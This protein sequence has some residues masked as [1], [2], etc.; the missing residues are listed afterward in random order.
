MSLLI[1]WLGKAPEVALESGESSFQNLATQWVHAVVRQAQREDHEATTKGE[2]DHFDQ[3]SN[4][5]QL[6]RK[7]FDYVEANASEYWNVPT[8]D[9]LDGGRS[10]SADE[11]SPGESADGNEEED[12]DESGGLFRAAYEDV[13]YRDSTDDGFEGAIFDTDSATDTELEQRSDQIIDRLTF[14]TGL[15]K[16]WTLTAAS[17]GSAKSAGR[18]AL[19]LP[20]DYRETLRSWYRSASQI[21]RGLMRLIETISQE[22]IGQPEGDHESMVEYDRRRLMKETMIEHAIAT[23]VEASEAER[24]LLAALWVF[25]ESFEGG[26]NNEVAIERELVETSELLAA[27]MRRDSDDTAKRFKKMLVDLPKLQI[28]Y[29]PLSKS[30]AGIDIARAR[31]R[32][33]IIENL[34]V[35]LPR[36]G[37]LADTVQLLDAARQMERNLPAGRGAVTQFDELFKVGFREMVDALVRATSAQ[38]GYLEQDERDADSVL[39]QCLERLTEPALETWL[40]HSRTLR[41]SILEGVR[42]PTAWKRLVEFI[43]NYGSDLFTQRFLALGN[44]RAILHCGTDHWLTEVARH[45]TAD[46]QLFAAIENGLP[47]EEAA[48]QLSFILEA[49]VENYDEYRD[50][51]STTTQSDR[52]ELLYMLL[53]F[54]RLRIEYDRVAWN[55]R[56]VVWAHEVLVRRGRNAGAQLWRRMLAERIGEEATRYQRRLTR[57]QKKYAIRMSS[58]TQRIGERFL[59]P[60]TIDR[61]LALV[62]P[63]VEHA[64]QQDSTHA[65]EILE[66]ETGLLMRE[67]SGAGTEGST[68]LLALEQE[69]EQVNYSGDLDVWP[70]NELLIQPIQPSLADVESQLERM[71]RRHL[72]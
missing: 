28:L 51:N 48:A 50:Y 16:L 72:E 38:T 24:F 49:I 37:L 66:E 43:Q 2:Q 15:A 71:S 33:R 25:D 70:G 69:I 29:V 58:V 52:G 57:L 30:G 56:P 64:G 20:A 60:M 9:R 27:V 7:F 53:D 62:K 63:A 19:E 5:W 35:A 6:L 47:Q 36:L 26:Q 68:W 39:V 10:A 3:R 34:L 42:Q 22:Q 67:P 13:V 40:A 65:F 4:V 45:G 41:L 18:D 31:M 44:I 55:L 46:L 61:M 11:Q 8:Y 1:H 59:L 54:I 21:R 32:Q 14:L 17:L 23:A 12:G